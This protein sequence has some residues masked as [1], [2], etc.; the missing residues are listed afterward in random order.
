MRPL[1]LCFVLSFCISLNAQQSVHYNLFSESSGDVTAFK[2]LELNQFD[3][4]MMAASQN[5]MI[6]FTIPISD[7]ETIS[8]ELSRK[9]LFKGEAIEINTSSG[10]DISI[11]PGLFYSGQIMGESASSAIFSSHNADLRGT[12]QRQD[13]SF[14]HIAKTEDGVFSVIPENQLL[15]YDGF[16]RCGEEP[17]D[18]DL[19]YQQDHHGSLMKNNNN[20]NVI[21]DSLCGDEFSI[22]VYYE[23]DHAT[24]ISENLNFEDCYTYLSHLHH[25]VNHIYSNIGHIDNNGDDVDL[26][27]GV[28]LYISSIFI[29]DH[30]DPYPLADI[31]QR[32][33]DFKFNRLDFNG[34]VAHLINKGFH[35]SGG[36]GYISETDTGSE[37]CDRSATPIES[38]PWSVS[39]QGSANNF[40]GD[41]VNI[42]Y[43]YATSIVAHE[44]GHNL[45]GRH[46]FDCYWY[47][48]ASQ[49]QGCYAIEDNSCC[50][51]SNEPSCAHSTC[52]LEPMPPSSDSTITA[53]YEATIMSYCWPDSTNNPNYSS[54]FHKLV[55]QN[56]LTNLCRLNQS[57]LINDTIPCLGGCRF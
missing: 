48:D 29:W 3:Y 44:I 42:V 24:F 19:K 4:V 47:Q 30:P 7:Q 17:K 36:R 56:I 13:G 26:P 38:G 35:E 51:N 39:L 11:E 55:A 15:D 1:I 22:G 34:D 16:L 50:P 54:P 52:I 45:G 18:N 9:K 2:A 25:I 23:L 28:D 37:L 12:I 21:P 33:I 27:G 5:E 31:P 6:D 32:L 46:T 14:Y 53:G 20:C 49:G 8:V 41:T 43:S 10:N 40:E 57:C